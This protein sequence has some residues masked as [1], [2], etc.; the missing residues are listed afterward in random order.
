MASRKKK[1]WLAAG[2]A[3]VLAVIVGVSV[4]RDSRR[5]VT[6]QTQK[7][8]KKDLVA[9]VSASGEVKPTR[10][11]NV[12]SNVSGRIVDLRVKEGDPV[13]QGQVLARID[14]TRFEAGEKQAAAAVEA[15]R[16]DLKRMEADLEATRLAFERARSMREQQLVSEQAFEQ[17]QAEVKMKQAAVESQRRRITQQSALLE[18]DRDDLAKTVV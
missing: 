13:K 8:G 11:V 15:A 10:Y 3:V 18:S 17:S 16:S 7:V 12:S 1:I 2:A 14:S 6:V 4:T 9:V 5:R